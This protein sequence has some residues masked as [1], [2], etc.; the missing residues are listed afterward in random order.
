MH[1]ICKCDIFQRS[2]DTRELKLILF[3]FTIIMVTGE[4]VDISQMLRYLTQ[5]NFKTERQKNLVNFV[6]GIIIVMRSLITTSL[7]LIM[8]E[9]LLS[10]K[11]F[12]S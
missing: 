11:Y 1:F 12:E 6:F 8:A 10:P 4:W 3:V 7:Q 9:S 2:F 5:Q